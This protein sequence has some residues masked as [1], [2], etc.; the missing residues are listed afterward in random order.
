MEAFRRLHTYLQPEC[1]E[2]LSRSG[3]E[4]ILGSK[5]PGEGRSRVMCSGGCLSH[6][7]SHLPEFKVLCRKRTNDFRECECIMQTEVDWKHLFNVCSLC[8]VAVASLETSLYNF[9]GSVMVL[10]ST[11]RRT[12]CKC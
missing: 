3:E 9:E 6:G 11:V 2:T 5:I 8:Y 4:F 1:L 7:S 12:S 10:L